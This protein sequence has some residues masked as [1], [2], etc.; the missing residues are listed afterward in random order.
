MLASLRR[1]KAPAHFDRPCVL[2]P[3]L[4]LHCAAAN[5]LPQIHLTLKRRQIDG[6]VTTVRG[7]LFTVISCFAGAQIS[8]QSVP[9]RRVV[10]GRE[11][12][13]DA[14][15]WFSGWRLLCA[16]RVFLRKMLL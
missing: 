2:T 11:K 3:N 4:H 7:D 5:G 8:T 10:G 1:G 14:S 15:S 6:A 12:L 16:R 9:R 13:F